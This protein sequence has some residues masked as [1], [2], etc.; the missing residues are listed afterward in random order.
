[1]VVEKD[2]RILKFLF[3]RLR[4]ETAG[5]VAIKIEGELATLLPTVRG[6]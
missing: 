1:M 4:D 6:A 5:S 3:G 2:W